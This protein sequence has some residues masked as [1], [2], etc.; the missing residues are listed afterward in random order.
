MSTICMGLCPGRPGLR[1]ETMRAPRRWPIWWLPLR[2][3]RKVNAKLG[4]RE[5]RNVAGY[6]AANSEYYLRNVRMH[7][8]GFGS[9]L[10]RN[11]TV[12]G[13][14]RAVGDTTNRPA[15]RGCERIG[16]K[17]LLTRLIGASSPWFYPLS[18]HTLF[19]F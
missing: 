6:D 13:R 3:K 16:L 17:C 15:I 18:F 11:R 12:L 2:L 9:I 1:F 5:F 7:Y 10:C 14:N 4:V 8:A 19:R